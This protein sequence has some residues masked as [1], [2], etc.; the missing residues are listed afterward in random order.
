MLGCGCAVACACASASRGVRESG[1]GGEMERGGAVSTTRTALGELLRSHAGSVAIHQ[2]PR[3]EPHGGAR[4]RLLVLAARTCR[5]L[6]ER[7][8]ARH[9]KVTLPEEA[10]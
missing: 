4:G 2:H 10:H 3:S 1:A 5:R 7:L 6:C 8:A 9:S